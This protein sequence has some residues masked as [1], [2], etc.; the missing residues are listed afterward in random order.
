MKDIEK[1]EEHFVAIR[2]AVSKGI[3]EKKRTKEELK[4]NISKGLIELLPNEMSEEESDD[5]LKMKLLI[6][7]EKEGISLDNAELIT[8]DEKNIQRESAKKVYER[9][10]NEKNKIF[11]NFDIENSSEHLFEEKLKEYE[12]IIQQNIFKYLLTEKYNNINFDN[13]LSKTS[14]FI[15]I[16]DEIFEFI[17]NLHIKY[18]KEIEYSPAVLQWCRAV[19][20]ELRNKIYRFI[21][22]KIIKKDIEENSRKTITYNKTYKLLKVN[23]MMGFYGKLEEYKMGEYVFNK[24]IKG[25]Y[26]NF[27]LE[28]FKKIIDLVKLIDDYRN[29]SAHSE[30]KYAMKKSDAEKCKE[31]IIAS[32]KILEILSKLETIDNM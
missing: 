18:K 17:D 29:D 28:D 13:L 4:E 2:E 12:N 3:L 31:Y 20:L 19:E 9:L 26:S 14:E 10:F 1:N 15:F 25:N 8:I 22:S 32:K 11:S 16:G 6:Q 23:N 24:Y 21:D 30:P 7:L 27:S 5:Y